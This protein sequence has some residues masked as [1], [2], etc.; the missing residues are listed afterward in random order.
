MDIEE[1]KAEAQRE[2]AEAQ[3]NEAEALREESKEA[4]RIRI[5]EAKMPAL[6]ED[7]ERLNNHVRELHQDRR[8][9]CLCEVCVEP[10]RCDVVA[11][12]VQ[13]KSPRKPLFVR[14]QPRKVH[15]S[16]S[17]TCKVT[18]QQK[19]KSNTSLLVKLR[20]GKVRDSSVM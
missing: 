18:L 8:P 1:E 9:S 7:I 19:E 3:R 13:C 10:K 16:M 4:E 6:H 20:L 14:Y 5:H 17:A 12:A 15:V 11:G 2:E